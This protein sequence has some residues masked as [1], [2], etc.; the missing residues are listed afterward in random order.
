MEKLPKNSMRGHTG[1]AR[2]IRDNYDNY[3]RCDTHGIYDSRD[4]YQGGNV[5]DLPHEVKN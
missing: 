3:A 2:N 5:G 4:N 1:K